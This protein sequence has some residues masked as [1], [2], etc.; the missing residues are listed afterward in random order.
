MVVPQNEAQ[1]LRLALLVRIFIATVVK[2]QWRGPPAE[3]HTA[4]KC[5]Q[6][7]NK[8]IYSELCSDKR[9]TVSPECR[10]KTERGRER[11]E[12]AEEGVPAGRE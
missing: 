1:I 9:L 5:L 4:N 2:D 11:G 10:A 7:V 8:N 6:T 12:S 3:P